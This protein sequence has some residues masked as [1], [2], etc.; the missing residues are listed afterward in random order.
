M[1]KGTLYTEAVYNAER[2]NAQPG[3]RLGEKKE[4]FWLKGWTGRLL[5]KIDDLLELRDE[6]RET[7]SLAAEA[8]RTQAVP[9]QKCQPLSDSEPD[10]LWGLRYLLEQPWATILMQGILIHERSGYM[11]NIYFI[12][13]LHLWTESNH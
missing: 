8:E 12:L 4:S 7:E 6:E 9:Q 13:F 10:L 11:W 5:K 3:R 1:N 2:Y